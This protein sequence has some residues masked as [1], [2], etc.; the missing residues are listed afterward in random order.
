MVVSDVV[1]ALKLEF[2]EATEAECER[3]TRACLGGGKE[4]DDDD[5]KQE[6]EHMLENYLDWRSCYGLD[7]N[8]KENAEER[9][10][11]E[12]EDDAADWRYAI[13]KAIEVNAQMQKAKELEQKLADN[14]KKAAKKSGSIISKKGENGA[15]INVGPVNYD[16]N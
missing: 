12:G 15:N 14:D 1:K 11:E 7:Y 3:F 8:R 10:Q 5:V 6:A 16:T 13:E 4:K 9:S 2:P